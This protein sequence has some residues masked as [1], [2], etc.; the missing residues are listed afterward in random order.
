MKISDYKAA[1]KAFDNFILDHP[2]SP[3]RKEA[4]YGKLEAAYLLA[5]NSVPYLV[6][7][8]LKTAK[9]Y[10]EGFSKYY[11]ESELRMDADVILQDIEKRLSQI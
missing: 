2:G 11:G 5:I 1:I 10:Y 6:E 8:R 3:Y 4:F 9:K 7:E